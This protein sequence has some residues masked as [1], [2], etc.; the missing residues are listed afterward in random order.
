MTKKQ[1]SPLES[2]FGND[3]LDK[4][5]MN[6]DDTGLVAEEHEVVEEEVEHGLESDERDERR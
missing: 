4:A 1:K 3:V 2:L 5:V 6:A